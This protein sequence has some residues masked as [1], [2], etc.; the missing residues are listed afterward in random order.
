MRRLN[1]KHRKSYAE[2]ASPQSI[3]AALTAEQQEWSRVNERIAWLEDLLALREEQ[4]ATGT[5]PTASTTDDQKGS[6]A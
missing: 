1:D 2:N 4:V 6:T 3:R 5:W